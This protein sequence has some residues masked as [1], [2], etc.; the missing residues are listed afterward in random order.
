MI[1][2]GE[3]NG[4]WVRKNQAGFVKNPAKEK[5]L[6]SIVIILDIAGNEVKNF[7]INAGRRD[8]NQWVSYYLRKFG[9]MWYK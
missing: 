9:K 4:D 3:G 5:Q 8:A 2:P 6:I 7:I 1:N